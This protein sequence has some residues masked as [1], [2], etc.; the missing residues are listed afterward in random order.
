MDKKHL[1]APCGLDCFNCGAYVENITDAYREK[2]VKARGMR[3]EDVACQG[4]R[5]LEGKVKYAQGDC[6]SWACAQ[7]EKVD[8]CF[9]CGKFPCPSL[10]PSAQGVSYPHNMKVY[11]LGRM[12]LLGVEGWIEESALIRKKYF[13]GRFVVGQ[14]PVLD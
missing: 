1:T 6:A 10:G 7:K 5:N 12:K 13:E 14:G 3:P 2:I 9:E 8:Y 11:N 4:C